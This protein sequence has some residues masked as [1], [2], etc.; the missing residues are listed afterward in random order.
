MP[1]PRP[2]AIE[3]WTAPLPCCDPEWE[4]AYRRFESPEEERR[5]FARRLRAFGVERWPR[6]AAVLELF[7]GRGG[8][9]HAWSDLGFTR[10]QGVDLSLDLLAGYRGPARLHV[11][12]C[13]ELK[14]PAAS[15][16]V[17]SVQGGL[18]HLPDLERD[19]PRVLDEVARVLRPGGRFLVVEPWATP[20]LDTLHA[21][22]RSRAV[23]ALW[24]RYDAFAEMVA[25]EEATYFAWLARPAWIE[26]EL[27]RRFA[28][29]RR[30]VG[31]GKFNWLGRARGG[32]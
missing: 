3:Q 2:P 20:F 24:G 4:A 11:G 17:V 29:E 31:W 18:H 16:D 7:C 1:E 22:R 5:K 19:L 14:L 10:L 9:L 8:A 12:D 23:R 13:R 25:R 32:R 21:F 30:R 26:E 27:R 15:Q 6:D 28:T